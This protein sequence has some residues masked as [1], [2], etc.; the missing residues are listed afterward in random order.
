MCIRD[1]EGTAGRADSGPGALG[2]AGTR[3]THGEL[4]G[5]EGGKPRWHRDNR[6]EGK[7]RSRG[8]HTKGAVS[9]NTGY[10]LWHVH[11]HTHAHVHIHIHTHMHIHTRSRAHTH[12]RSRALTHMLTHKDTKPISKNPKTLTS[13]KNKQ[14]Q[15]KTK[16]SQDQIPYKF[17]MKLTS[18][19]A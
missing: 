7:R 9:E 2:P 12:T 10:I 15:N 6:G 3:P 18:S 13:H 4:A 19:R 1:R 8:K 5:R 14:K 16:K 17:T 11:I